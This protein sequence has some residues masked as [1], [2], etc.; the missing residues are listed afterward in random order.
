MAYITGMVSS[1]TE[2]ARNMKANSNMERSMEKE[3]STVFA[4]SVH[5]MTA[6]GKMIR[7]MDMEVLSLS[8]ARSIVDSGNKVILMVMENLNTT[9]AVYSKENFTKIKKKA[10]AYCTSIPA[11]T[12]KEYG[13]MTGE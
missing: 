12:E 9:V 10:E 11:A 13:K 1:P 7:C 2:M 6:I 8:T 4:I 5:I 3:S